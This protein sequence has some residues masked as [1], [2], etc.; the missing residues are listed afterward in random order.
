M[1]DELL[2]APVPFIF[3]AARAAVDAISVRELA[4]H[5]LCVDLAARRLRFP[6]SPPLPPLPAALRGPLLSA[7]QRAEEDMQRREAAAH[8]PWTANAPA[9]ASAPS[10]P[11]KPSASAPA[12]APPVPAVRLA[13][14]SEDE[15]S[16]DSWRGAAREVRRA[17]AAAMAPLAEA[18]WASARHGMGADARARAAAAFPAH[19]RD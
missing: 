7:L 2:Q 9:S 3:G 17:C 4:P 11:S 18:A 6:P 16:N 13:L 19:E 10:K 1:R 14:P 8:A 15:L 5:L 12:P